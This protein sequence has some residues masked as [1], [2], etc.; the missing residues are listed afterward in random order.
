MRDGLAED[1]DHK[2]W[3][4]TDA[5]GLGEIRY[6]DVP[7]TLTDGMTRKHM[8]TLKA[9]YSTR[10]IRVVP[11]QCLGGTPAIYIDALRI[12]WTHESVDN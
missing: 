9:G 12:G 10:S 4:S 5:S 7:Q 6:D 2:K 3:S 8:R 1:D 11:Q